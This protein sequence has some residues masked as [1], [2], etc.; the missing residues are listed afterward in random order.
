M[1]EPPG[2]IE[3][4]SGHV[5]HTEKAPIFRPSLNHFTRHARLE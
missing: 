5:F 3:P 1:P 2:K 4:E